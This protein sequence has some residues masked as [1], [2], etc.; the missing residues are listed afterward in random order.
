MFKKALFQFLLA[1]STL[2]A[3]Q[4]AQAD[5]SCRVTVDGMSF[6]GKGYD[7]G[8]ALATA[9]DACIREEN[10]SR[11]CM[12]APF[13]CRDDDYVPPPPSSLS[14]CL[15]STREG[16]FT[17]Y[18]YSVGEA[19]E[20]ARNQCLMWADYSECMSAPISCRQ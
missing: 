13:S 1:L 20:N 11:V 19:L 4:V 18:G 16:V 7:L 17:G 5:V 9:R 8:S 14:R 15:L 2:G 10:N 6:S 3:S 12:N